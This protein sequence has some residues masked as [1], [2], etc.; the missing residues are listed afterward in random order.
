MMLVDQ[1]EVPLAAL[2]V[3]QFRD[4]LRLGTGFADDGLQ[5]VILETSLR[6][7]MST[8]EARTGKALLSRRMCWTINRWRNAESQVLP[9]APV[10]A[11][12]LIRLSDAQDQVTEIDGATLRLVPDAHTPRI[13]ARAGML[14]AIAPS[15]LAEVEF[16]AGYGATWADVPHDL[17]RATLMMAAHLYEHRHGDSGPERMPFGLAALVDRYRSLRIFGGGRA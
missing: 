2:P 16:T 15:G 11:V 9:I 3:A 14:P 17:A 4:H 8:I 7:A 5:D 12:H 1:T 6:A 13:C 10:S